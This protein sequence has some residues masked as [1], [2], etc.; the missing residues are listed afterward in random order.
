MPP[1][2]SLVASTLTRL[3]NSC[4][5][6]RPIWADRLR[7]AREAAGLTQQQLADR[8]DGVG[9]SRLGNYE[10]G[11]REPDLDTLRRIARELCTSVGYLTG[12]DLEREPVLNSV[13]VAHANATQ[14]VRFITATTPALDEEAGEMPGFDVPAWM[15]DMAK[16][17]RESARVLFAPDDAMAHAIRKGALVIVDI[18]ETALGS[19]DPYVVSVGGRAILRRLL[20]MPNG[21]VHVHADNESN[22]AYRAY[23]TAP[24]SLQILGRVALW[25]GG[26]S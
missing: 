22:P 19:H 1:H 24:E 26:G 17:P 5:S 6:D 7:L 20:Y 14:S 2:A 9:A 12:D 11:F 4:M 10:T 8:L 23:D 13:D 18:R 16:V 25:T 3:H 21:M 15:L